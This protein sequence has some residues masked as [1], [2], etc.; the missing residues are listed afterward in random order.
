MNVYVD[1]FAVFN[2][3]II[4]ATAPIRLNI[5]AGSNAAILSWTN[6]AFTLQAAPFVTGLYTNIPGATS[7]YTNP[8]TSTQQYFRLIAN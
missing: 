7:P 6:S 1:D 3:Q 8:V 4:T 5:E 2:A